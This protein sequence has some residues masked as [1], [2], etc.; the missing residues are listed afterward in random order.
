MMA[1]G[2]K[3]AISLEK[4]SR[5]IATII[6]AMHPTLRFC[7]AERAWLLDVIHAFVRAESPSHDKA[8][9]DRCGQVVASALAACGGQL[10]LHARTDAGDH[11]SADFGAA[12]GRRVLILTH[13]DTVWPLGQ[14]V[15]MPLEL[16]EGKLYGPG[17]YD[18]KA[19]IAI[20]LLAIRAWMAASPCA[21]RVTML[22]TTDE[23]IGSRSSRALIE[24]EAKKSDAVFV[25][26]PTLPGGIL[27]TARKGC[28]DFTLTV[29]GKSAHA[30]V[31]PTKGVNAIAELAHQILTL[32]RMTDMARG[33]SVTVTV[34]E[35]GARTNVVPDRAVAQIDAR[36]PSMADAARVARAIEGL[37]PV[38]PGA[39]LAVTGGFGRPPLERT[40]GVV[41]LF[42]LA[43]AAGA[44]LGIAVEE[45]AT[46]GGSDGNF[47]AA[48]G[49]PTLDGLGAIG[50]GA[51]ALH[52]HV[53]VASLPIRAALLARLIE[54]ALATS[55]H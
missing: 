16:R 26:E 2:P 43:R 22:C 29:H 36:A 39:T 35:G 37:V 30:G 44:E 5:S 17:V 14:L 50:D 41:R 10:A 49:I 54:K 8:A 3:R 7:E 53:D 15:R 42:E 47:T 45:G 31:D 1:T 4:G 21:G 19:G 46:G 33:V 55:T 34:V 25:L 51:H 11:V 40:P 9:V 23:E 13:F 38:L 20:G 27:K 24:A 48:I 32:Q 18:M 52:E 12:D 28:G 6:G